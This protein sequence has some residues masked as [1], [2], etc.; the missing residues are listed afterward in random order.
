MSALQDDVWFVRAHA[1]RTCGQILLFNSAPNLIRA[2]ADPVW[3]VRHDAA[4]SLITFLKN[5]PSD[6]TRERILSS[7][8]LEDRFAR[9]MI[10]Q[11]LTNSG[12]V[13]NLVDEFKQMNTKG[14]NARRL[15][16]FIYT[17]GGLPQLANDRE[18]QNFFGSE[19]KALTQ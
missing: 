7:I 2:L 6:H 17:A 11:I 16:A 14:E 10:A 3:W 4:E 8:D 5:D 9:N 19:R 15:L 1:A 12:T 13:E 18:W